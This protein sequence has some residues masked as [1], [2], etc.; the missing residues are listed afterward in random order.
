MQLAAIEIRKMIKG[1]EEKAKAAALAQAQRLAKLKEEEEILFKHAVAARRSHFS[2]GLGN[3]Y[4]RWNEL[5]WRKDDPILAKS[6][7]VRIVLIGSSTFAKML[8][9]R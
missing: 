4:D 3:L 9:Y 5:L 7:I 6:E 8:N 1:Q 2:Q